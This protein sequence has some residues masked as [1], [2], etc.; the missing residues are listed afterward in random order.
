M[1]DRVTW[2]DNI[3]HFFTQM[4]V[5]CMRAKGMDLSDY[6][7]VK[8]K[9]ALI[10][11]QLQARVKDPNRGMPKGGRAWPQDKIDA[12]ENWIKDGAPKSRTT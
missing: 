12:F 1:A 3:R 5:G 9:A 10:L 6:D 8:V 2:D 7:T 11:G 4:D